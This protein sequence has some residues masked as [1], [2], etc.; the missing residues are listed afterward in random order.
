MTKN[1]CTK[2]L[3]SIGIPTFNRPYNLKRALKNITTQSYKNLEIIVSDNDSS[4]K[5][6]KE[7]VDEYSQKDSRIKYYK[8][9]KNIGVL[10]NAE[11]VLKKAT[12]EYFTWFSDD[13]WRSPE[14]IENMVS[15][16]DKDE[17]L[18]MAFCDYHEVYED[19]NPAIGYPSTH[20]TIFK[21]FQSQYRL[22]RI[23]NYYWQKS[24]YGKCNLFYSV[25]RKRVLDLID[26]KKITENYIHLN[27]DNLIV[28]HL[29]QLGPVAISKDP[30]CKLTCGNQKYYN[31]DFSNINKT[32]KHWKNKIIELYK[33]YSVDRRL[34]SKNTSSFI[35]KT[36]INL[37]FV[38]KYIL[39]FLSIIF[40]KTKF[41][42][43]KEKLILKNIELEHNFEKPISFINKLNLP[44]VTLVA[45][46]TQNVEETLQ[47]IL[48]SC[49]EIEYGSVK[50]LSHFTPFCKNEN[51]EFVR[52]NKM[53]DIDDWSHFIVYE[54][55]KYIDTEYVLLVHADGF[56]V[57]HKS[58]RK[59]FLDYDYIGAPWP[60]PTDDFSYRDINRNIVRVGNS[61]SLRS[62]KLL[63]LPSKLELP[64]EAD[65]GFFNEDGFLCVKNKHVLEDNGIKFA[66]IDIAKYFSHETMIP[67]IQN[68]K[69]FVFHKWDGSNSDYPNFFK[70]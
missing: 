43:H 47:A 51:I 59:E 22:V 39:E 53:K 36:L 10:A 30:M 35:E 48:Y 23:V 18:N 49:R 56:V 44:N 27:M 21:P 37:L 38:P 16:L 42:F 28:F 1:N 4:S 45:V 33:S 17:K 9:E 14:F 6:I 19:G 54:L 24:V 64:W 3:V 13:D 55:D 11:F 2:G 5:K 65:H 46:A 8:Q 31:D 25:F 63:R 58:W 7:I 62:K 15:I 32:Q 61:V 67:E 34:Y 66:Q 69:P 26:I 29:L 52:I 57:N 20:L 50:L 70:K 60:M 12:G 68:I 41:I 40:N